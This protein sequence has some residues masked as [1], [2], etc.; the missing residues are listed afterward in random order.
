MNAR[1]ASTFHMT[2]ERSC[3]GMNGTDL[4]TRIVYDWRGPHRQP[5]GVYSY[6]RDLDSVRDRIETVSQH[7]AGITSD[8]ATQGFDLDEDASFVPIYAHRYVVCTQ[9]LSTSV[10]VSIVVNDIDAVVYGDSLEDYLV[11]EFLSSQEF[12]A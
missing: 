11:K 3:K 1:S 4:A 12:C 5:V 6:P 8:L 9:N 10:V 2:L 7:R